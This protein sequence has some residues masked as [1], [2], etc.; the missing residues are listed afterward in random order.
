MHFVGCCEPIPVLLLQS[1]PWLSAAKPTLCWFCSRC[2]SRFWLWIFDLQIDRYEM[3][4]VH[5]LID[6]FLAGQEPNLWAPHW[7]FSRGHCWRPCSCSKRP[8]GDHDPTIPMSLL[9]VPES[10]SILIMYHYVVSSDCYVLLCYVMYCYVKSLFCYVMLC[11]VM[12]SHSFV[13]WCYP[14]SK[15]M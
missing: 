15:I 9:I 7:H 14:S 4:R 1:S 2:C 10:Q 13:V 6:W 5:S 3:I 8:G 11:I 12:L